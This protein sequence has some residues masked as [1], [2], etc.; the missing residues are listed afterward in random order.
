MLRSACSA[1]SVV[2]FHPISATLGSPARASALSRSLRWTISPRARRAAASTP[3][4][5]EGAAITITADWSR[6]KALRQAGNTSCGSGATKKATSSSIRPS[7]SASWR[8]SMAASCQRSSPTMTST[9]SS[10]RVVGSS[11][12]VTMPVVP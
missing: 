2:W 7:D 1:R 3:S 5:A 12:S 11:S 6:R 9:Q 10:A 4:R 8:A